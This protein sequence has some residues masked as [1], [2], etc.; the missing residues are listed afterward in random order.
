[1]R[2][3]QDFEIKYDIGHVALLKACQEVKSGYWNREQALGI[4]LGIWYVAV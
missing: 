3:M 2:N 4:R 1:M